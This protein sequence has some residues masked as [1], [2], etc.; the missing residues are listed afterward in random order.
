MKLYL[1]VIA[2]VIVASGCAKRPGAIAPATVPASAYS[3]L[4]CEQLSAELVKEN[5]TLTSLSASQNEAANADAVGVF[6]VA[7]PV[8]SLVGADK[9]GDIAVSKGKIVSIEATRTGKGC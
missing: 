4:S 8:G 5:Q 1:M 6:L 9:E 7:I 2:A 3:N